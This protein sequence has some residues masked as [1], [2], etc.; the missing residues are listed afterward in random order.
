M[1]F[2]GRCQVAFQ[3][4]RTQ[5]SLQPD[6]NNT[7][8]WCALQYLRTWGLSFLFFLLFNADSMIQVPGK[9]EAGVKLALMAMASNKTQVQKGGAADDD[10]EDQ[11]FG[12]VEQPT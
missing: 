11:F 12:Y 8:D 2:A 1:F 9:S 4:A 5:A 10:E 7:S 6:R 3:T